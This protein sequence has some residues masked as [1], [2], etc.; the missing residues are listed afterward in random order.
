MQVLRS[1]A[2]RV[3][4][5]AGRDETLSPYASRDL[6]SLVTALIVLAEDPAA[7]ASGC[8]AVAAYAAAIATRARRG[9]KVKPVGEAVL[10]CVLAALQRHQG[11]TAVQL[12][13]CT[14]LSFIIDARRGGSGSMRE[15][16]SVPPHLVREFA[17][18]ATGAARHALARGDLETA[19]QA[20]RAL[21]LAMRPPSPGGLIADA[22]S[23]GALEVASALLD[24]L[25]S[26]GSAHRP[27]EELLAPFIRSCAA[28][29]ADLV[30]C[31][32]PLPSHKLVA[33]T[34]IAG[35]VQAALASPSARAV[36]SGA[37]AACIRAVGAVADS[38]EQQQAAAA[39]VTGAFPV[40]GANAVI[41][42]ADLRR[43]SPPAAAALPLH[44]GNDAPKIVSSACV[45][46]AAASGAVHHHHRSSHRSSTGSAAGGA[47]SPPSS[48]SSV[49]HHR[50]AID[51]RADAGAIT[52]L[53]RLVRASLDLRMDGDC[54]AA[55][56][57]LIAAQASGFP[58][59]A[60]C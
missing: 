23:A 25:C 13:G 17:D 43:G 46:I 6:D 37:L 54:L 15:T 40:P 41:A 32:D 34:S 45:V 60:T 53:L 2:A 52:H 31:S 10:V 42:G 24:Q 5:S 26:P 33:P 29:V 51:K 48:T 59:R 28:V 57:A 35:K 8:A 39:G 30:L 22:S 18:T 58:S 55:V 38:L 16:A 49:P 3:K 12:H 9:A 14:A 47:A 20:V 4:A 11:D 27:R 44:W 21:R 56:A 36:S 1:V 19:G 50:P 7:Q